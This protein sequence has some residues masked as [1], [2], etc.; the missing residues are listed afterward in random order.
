MY[1]YEERIK[2]VKLYIQYCMSAASVIRELGYPNRHT[3]KSW[4][5]EFAA[6]D[7]LHIVSTR[8]SKYTDM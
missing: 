7:D 3:L 1:S 8:S 6:N 4:Y 2:A 5:K